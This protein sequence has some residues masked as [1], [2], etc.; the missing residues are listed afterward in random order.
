MSGRQCVAIA[1][2]LRFGVRNQ[3]VGTEYQKVF[4]EGARSLVGVSGLATDAQS[5]FQRIRTRANLYRLREEREMRP[6]VLASM[7]SSLLYDHR[8]GPYFVEPVVAG[9]EE[10]EEQEG[11]GEKTTAKATTPGGDG[12]DGGDRVQRESRFKPFLCGMDMLGA[13]MF[14]AD[15]VCAGTGVDGVMG[16]C[17][18][19]WRPDLEPDD[20]FEVISQCLLAAAD[21]DAF[22]GW[23]A[24][25]H[26][27]TPT[28]LTTRILKS[29]QD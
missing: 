22:S 3:T 17:E 12:E 13:P 20:L 7:V 1:S 15:F 25:V 2:D 14:A 11:T 8:F 27:L 16:V 9:L 26:V 21:R 19:L 5:V 29:R 23:G 28:E 18:A 6:H 24:V 4:R 10:E